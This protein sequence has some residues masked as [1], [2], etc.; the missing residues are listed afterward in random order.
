MAP[1]PDPRATSLFKCIKEGDLAALDLLVQQDPSLLH[2]TH[3][4]WSNAPVL[5]YAAHHGH[6]GMVDYLAA[7]GVPLDQTNSN[8]TTA[9]MRAALSGHGAVVGR[10]VELGADPTLQDRYGLTALHFAAMGGDTAAAGHLLTLGLGVNSVTK[11][12]W[13]P[14]HAAAGMGNEDMIS[15]LVSNGGDLGIQDR[16]GDSPLHNAVRGKRA[17]SV[18]LLLQLGAPGD[19]VRTVPTPPLSSYR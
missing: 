11:N 5:V 16:D 10:L 14:L 19:L 15:Y 1:P 18:M 12:G 7:Q 2:L 9:M 8:G 6:L 13:T 3:P 4:E 17:S